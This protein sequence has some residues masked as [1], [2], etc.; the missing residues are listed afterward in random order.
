MRISLG[1]SS[2]PTIPITR[3][4]LAS[5]S[6][7]PR[8]SRPTS[9]SNSRPTCSDCSPRALTSLP[10]T[11]D[12]GVR[13]GLLDLAEVLVARSDER[14]HEVRARNDDGGRGLGRCHEVVE[15][16][17]LIATMV[18]ARSVGADEAFE[19]AGGHEVPALDA[20]GSRARGRGSTRWPGRASN[21]RS[22]TP[23]SSPHHRAAR[24][25]QDVGV[26]EQ[27][28]TRPVLGVDPGEHP[29]GAARRPPRASRRRRDRWVHTDQPGTSRRISSVRLP[30][31]A[32]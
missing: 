28:R 12:L 10:R 8:C 26:G 9:S 18:A 22:R 24:I 5:S 15:L 11:L 3:R 19:V 7:W 16:S 1:R 14:S 21:S 6:S 25:A 23:A 4:R 27:R 31:A 13:E 30:S 29:V 2:S 17:A 20:R 32:P